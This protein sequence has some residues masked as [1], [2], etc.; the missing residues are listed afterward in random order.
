MIIY[1]LDTNGIVLPVEAGEIALPIRHSAEQANYPLHPL[2][3]IGDI[4]IHGITDPAERLPH[5]ILGTV[6]VG[7]N[8]P[9]TVYGSLL[10]TGLPT[11]GGRHHVLTETTALT[12]LDLIDT[13]R[14]ALRRS[15][16]YPQHRRS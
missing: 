5:N 8:G 16:L 1:M 3:T 11:T 2:R 12:A 7:T 14:D 4:V 9:A 13:A 10:L 6:L 15:L